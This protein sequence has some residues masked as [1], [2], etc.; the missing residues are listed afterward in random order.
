M[1][2]LLSRE[3]LQAEHFGDSRSPG[4]WQCEEEGWRYRIEVVLKAPGV[5]TAPAP[6][7]VAITRLRNGRGFE[8][9]V[10][11]ERD[12]RRRFAE[13]VFLLASK[14]K[15]DQLRGI[16]DDNAGFLHSK[17]I[18]RLN[19]A[20]RTKVQKA[21]YASV[22]FLYRQSEKAG[23]GEWGFLRN[24]FAHRDQL[25]HFI[26]RCGDTGGTVDTED[27]VWWLN[28]RPE[29]VS[30]RDS[31][32][33]PI[34][35]GM[36][37]KSL[38]KLFP[39]SCLLA[40]AEY[41]AFLNRLYPEPSLPA[42][43]PS[44][45][46]A[47]G[48]IAK[49]IE[50][51]QDET[52]PA[53]RKVVL[54]PRS[55]P[56]SVDEVLKYLR[57]LA[58]ECAELPYYFPAHLK[59]D[60]PGKSA[61]EN[62][63]QTV[64]VVED[65]GAFHRRLGEERER[66]RRQGIDPDALAYSPSK[67]MPEEEDDYG[68][69]MVPAETIAWDERTSNRFH[70]VTILG[71]PGTGKSWL[72]RYEAGRL[73]Y[74]AIERLTNDPTSIDDIILP[75]LVRLP[76]L[77]KRKG[78][79]EDRIVATI[80]REPSSRL[81][82]YI[83]KQLNSN[84][85]VVLLDAWDE[86]SNDKKGRLKERIHKFAREHPVRIL[87]AS[88]IVGYE[89]TEP[90]LPESRELELLVWEW[91]QIESFVYK[92][93]GGAKREARRF[94]HRLR[95]HPPSRGLARIPLMLMLLC[96][97]YPNG[98]LPARRPDLYRDCLYGLL[99]DWHDQDKE[100]VKKY[101]AS[102]HTYSYLSGL[103]EVLERLSLE[104]FTKGHEQFRED[105][106]C[107]VVESY[108]ND[109]YRN[110]PSHEFKRE[111]IT[112]GDLIERFKDDGVL[113]PATVGGRELRFLHL[114]FQEYLAARALGRAPDCTDIA[115]QHVY[116]PAW[117]QVLTMLAGLLDR[118]GPY[119]AA[120]LRKNREDVLCR[121]FFLALQS[122]AE[123]DG[124]RLPRE[125]YNRMAHEV[126]K[127][128][129]SE[130]P[131]FLED[132]A[133][134]AIRQLHQMV[135]RLVVLT[136][137]TPKVAAPAI[138][139]L[140]E[141]GSERAVPALLAALQDRHHAYIRWGAASA[142]EAIGSERAIGALVAA[143]R[144]EDE[145]VRRTAASALG[146]IGSEQAVP[147]LVEALHDRS[148]LVGTFAKFALERIGSERA[149]LSLVKAMQDWKDP[150]ASLGRITS[151][152]AVPALVDA[153]RNGPPS[154]R[155][156]AAKAL[157]AIGSARAVPALLEAL[158]DRDE[159]VCREAAHA[160]GKIGS[161]RA[162]PAL[163]ELL[164]SKSSGRRSSAVSALGL[165]GAEEALHPVLTLLKDDKCISRLAAVLALGQIVSQKAISALAELLQNNSEDILVREWAARGLG[166][167]GSE[168]EVQLLLDALQDQARS[169]RHAAAS[170]LGQ[171]GSEQAVAT[172]GEVLRFGPTS[173]RCD[174]AQAL[175][176]IG[177][178]Q[179]VPPLV[180]ALRDEDKDVRRA[181]AQALGAIGS[182]RAAPALIE[183]LRDKDRNVRRAAARA[184]GVI[185]SE[186]AE[187]VLVQML[188]DEDLGMRKI[189]A[190]ALLRIRPKRAVPIPIHTAQNQATKS[191]SDIQVDLHTYLNSLATSLGRLADLCED[192]Q[193][194]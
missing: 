103:I 167:I 126:V 33:S 160:L 83:H 92:W 71:D 110:R 193:T 134:R 95:R 137:R 46:H 141:I 179:A 176:Q 98:V 120:L 69:C 146:E 113:I 116:E 191:G 159:E 10:I 105:A 78:T 123:I 184:L 7:S 194:V 121:P 84:R 118:P 21:L 147:A 156:L 32:G 192:R 119:M 190:D 166:R 175:G 107:P 58:E 61:F 150:W 74:R 43:T 133:R 4:V 1:T 82:G 41:R 65:R 51:N 148:F 129:L 81:H 23:S 2:E 128:H 42:G 80:A 13:L 151:E 186:R 5:R 86:V 140:G 15:Y 3:I 59:D 91:H 155:P 67:A 100:R 170:A 138:D 76:D 64:R 132:R 173:S 93:F 189:A 94:L 57:D 185:G 143:L 145:D 111:E 68:P 157:R 181:A 97:A 54:G 53:L 16:A 72:L 162:V 85:G 88:R 14:L 75:I 127:I 90:P 27:F 158:G 136:R 31:S 35:D 187:P 139:M 34:D 122:S 47:G 22:G 52:R 183:A 106:I 96:R 44:E 29:D 135:D 26:C 55:E 174:F 87:L 36:L 56:V 142:L 144:D 172:L 99:R 109:L 163:I 18:V 131:V 63:R 50:V 114:T 38:D 169:V 182:E 12:D 20:H 130:P 62:V 11:P 37:K 180:E 102:Q 112:P 153:L 48:G 168:P 24:L 66:L 125:V 89:L 108:L 101:P 188:E 115:V 117:N 161:P 28:V 152:D 171:I 45:L 77:A 154:D 17:E 104:L 49:S 9:T 25:W 124:N 79:L 8:H 165:I 178:E 19:D 70:R 40:P 164:Q 177:S 73:A 149:I 30:F 6:A 60:G 39:R